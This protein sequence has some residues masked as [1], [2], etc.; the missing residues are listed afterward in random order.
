MEISKGPFSGVDRCPEF[1]KDLKRLSKKYP[2]LPEDINTFIKTALNGL[3]KLGQEI[4]GI[5]QVV[6]LGV[7]EPKVYKAL[8]FACKSLKGRG[9]ASGMRVVYA[10]KKES[11]EIYLIE[12]YF[13]ADKENEDRDRIGRVLKG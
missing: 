11:D 4:H 13:K 1:D 12:I 8:K 5:V 3:H 7:E 9:A 2:S 10:Y 6:G